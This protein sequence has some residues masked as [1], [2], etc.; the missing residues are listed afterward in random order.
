MARHRRHHGQRHHRR[1]SDAVALPG[2]GDI[3]EEVFKK[4]VHGPD[5]LV[6][7]AAM[8]FGI[9]ILNWSKRRWA[10]MFP[11][12]ILP[13]M[14]ALAGLV[15]GGLMYMVDKKVL[16]KP[17]SAGGHALGA[18]SAG[19]AVTVLNWAKGKYPVYFA[20]VVDLKL[21]G[22]II[23]DRAPAM[24]AGYNGMIVDDRMTRAPAL[25]GYADNPA[26]ADLA[27]LSQMG[28]YDDFESMLG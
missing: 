10:T 6:G 27:A 14:P 26:L 24:M 5:V 20:D 7:G 3:T 4:P 1:Y 17:D 23:N 25:R 15:G 12:S 8:L 21:A 28:E 13:I 9:W 18:L 16:D 19:L 2:F 22:M 11:P